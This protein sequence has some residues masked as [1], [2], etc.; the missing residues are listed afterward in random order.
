[1]TDTPQVSVVMSVYNGADKLNAS[2]ESIMSQGGVDFEFIIVNDGSTDAS[3][4]MLEGIAAKDARIRLLHQVNRGLT[5]ALIKGCALARGKY[6]ARQDCGDRSLPERLCTQVGVME[7]RPGTALVS[8]GMRMVGPQGE[9]LY[10]VVQSE[11]DASEGLFAQELE[12]LRG[13]AHHGSTMFRRDLYERAG[14]YREQFYFAQDLDLWTR[15][16]EHGQHVAIAEILYQAEFTIGSISSVQRTLQMECTKII[17]E[18]TRLRRKGCGD[19][20][21][22]SKASRII[23][24]GRKTKPSSLASAYYFVGACLSK[25]GDPRARRYYLE[26]LRANPLHLRSAMRLLFG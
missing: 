20:Q 21:T 1:M 9:P 11:K 17:L 13:P 12:H 25:R 2:I 16:A 3:A 19:T 18:C 7:S 24:D 22:A 4:S 14:G 8:S 15:M 6:I 23:P 26:A 10:E 5:K